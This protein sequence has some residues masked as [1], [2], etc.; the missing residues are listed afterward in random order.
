LLKD[1][2][3]PHAIL[4]NSATNCTNQQ[5]IFGAGTKRPW[6]EMQ[7]FTNYFLLCAGLSK[8]QEVGKLFSVEEAFKLA[9]LFVSRM[10]NRQQICMRTP[11]IGSTF[12]NT[13]ER[14]NKSRNIIN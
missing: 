3:V 14:T 1:I 8:Q 13:A 7:S 12:G 2:C 6:E 10:Q 11:H 5:I 4:V 9:I